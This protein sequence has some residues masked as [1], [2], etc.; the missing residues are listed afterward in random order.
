M[1]AVTTRRASPGQAAPDRPGRQRSLA[2]RDRT[3]GFMIGLPAVVI[4]LVVAVYPM[5]ASI[6]T[7]LYDQSLLRSD[8]TFIGLHNYALVWPDF[9]DR[10]GTT[11][12]FSTLATVGPVFVGVA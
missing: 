12:T 4:F 5:V 8:R 1:V 7:S 10:L 6:G 9:V 2:V 11:L 3:F